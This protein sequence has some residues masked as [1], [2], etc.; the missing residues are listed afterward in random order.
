MRKLIKFLL[1]ILIIV[2]AVITLG[3]IFLEYLIWMRL[4]RW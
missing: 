4:K 1:M 2:A 3:I